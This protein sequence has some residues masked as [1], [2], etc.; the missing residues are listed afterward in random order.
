MS[1]TQLYSRDANGVTF[2]NPSDPDFTVRFKNTQSRKSL[3]GLTT[4]NYVEE[5]VFNDLN[6][7]TINGV[8]ANDSVSVRLRISGS[9]ESKARV[10]AILNSLAAQLPTWASNSVPLGFEPVEPPDVVG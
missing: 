1:K 2:A 6:P 3:G 10:T 7:I 4:Q 9:A 8:S 5:I